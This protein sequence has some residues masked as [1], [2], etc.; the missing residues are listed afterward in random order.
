MTPN[1][2]P[3][4]RIMYVEDDPD[5]QDIVSLGLKLGGNYAVKVCG[6][7]Q[8]A[9]AEIADFQPDLVILDVMMPE[10]SGPE[11]LKELRK[12]PGLEDMPMVFMTSKIQPAQLAKYKSLGAI[13]VIKKPL[14]PLKLSAQ[15]QAIWANRFNVAPPPPELSGS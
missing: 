10:M 1:N 3:L 12:I 8:Q 11:T 13:G 4:H 15:V 14:N 9:L 7:G 6:S 2:K 5:L